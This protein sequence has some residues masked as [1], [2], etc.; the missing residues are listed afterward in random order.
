MSRTFM[1]DDKLIINLVLKDNLLEIF[2]KVQ[3]IYP[4]MAN[5]QIIYYI[6][7]EYDNYQ[8]E[9]KQNINVINALVETFLSLPLSAADKQKVLDKAKELLHEK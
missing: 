6:M 8:Q 9:K 2:R 7:T 4:Y 5:S 3:T 1:A